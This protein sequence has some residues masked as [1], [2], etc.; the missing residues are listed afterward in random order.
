[1]RNHCGVKPIEANVA[2]IDHFD[3]GLED[4]SFFPF[5]VF[6]VELLVTLDEAESLDGHTLVIGGLWG[7]VAAQQAHLLEKV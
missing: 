6:E 1:M 2:A 7:K 5:F 3:E 4:K